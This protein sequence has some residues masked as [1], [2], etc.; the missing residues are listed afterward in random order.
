MA[1]TGRKTFTA[2][3]VLAAADV[4]SYLQDQSVMVFDSSAARSSAIGTAVSEGMV[5]YLKDTDLVE[6]YNGSAWS[7]VAP[8]STSGLNLVSPT[9]IASG[10]G[11]SSASG[12]AVTF[13]GVTSIS[14]NGVFTST[15]D[16]YRVVFFGYSGFSGGQTLFFRNRVSG[17]DRT[18]AEYGDNRIF[19]YSSTV[20]SSGVWGGT[21]VTLGAWTGNGTAVTFPATFDVTQPNLALPTNIA[22]QSSA[23]QLGSPLFIGS[24][25]TGVNSTSSAMDGF[26]I[27][28]SAGT[29][30]GTVM[31]YG[32]KNS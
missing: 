10:G 30:T 3:A 15:Y 4:Q 16:N 1:G 19:G 20:G 23:P 32:Y 5:S 6:S 24:A 29:M 27:V 25:F 7:S 11:S 14:L 31:V 13:T 21:A 17:S 2:G 26:S 12:G 9:S 18:A 22:G 28:L 8:A